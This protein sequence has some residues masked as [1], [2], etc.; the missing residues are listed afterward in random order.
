MLMM[1]R[2]LTVSLCLLAAVS[3]KAQN[4][5]DLIISEVMV[6]NTCS[7]VD[8]FGE[9]NQWVE[10]FNTSQGTVNF[11]GCFFSDDPANL[12]KSPI[13]KSDSRTKIGPRQVQLFYGGNEN[14][15]GTFYLNF[16][17]KPGS[18]LYLVSND[19]RTIIDSIDIPYDI[20][21]GKSIAKFADDNKQM[22]FDRIQAAEP[23]PMSINGSTNQKS[24]AETI[25]E[26]DP[27]GWTLT[28]VSVSVVFLALILLFIIYNFSGKCFSGKIKFKNPFK[29][30]PKPAKAV[31]MA[32][33]GGNQDEIAAAI[34]MALNAECSG[35]VEAAIALAMHRF[36][37]E[38]THDAE[39]FVITIKPHGS[40][41]N[42]KSQ[43]FRKQPR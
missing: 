4:V 9:H 43:I 27:H 13:I 36:L 37:S 12:R 22:V 40:A 25:Q 5:I 19:G 29:R 42:N 15:K 17:L 8:D 39:P 38:C 34:A 2:L 7:V 41:W 35:E 21:E 1:K 32:A 26:T 18:T 20:P 3:L 23:S 30:A 24:K 11:G 14:A 16:Q 28:I 10:I 6:D 33:A 31:G